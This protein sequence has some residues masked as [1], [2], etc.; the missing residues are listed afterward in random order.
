MVD[1]ATYHIPDPL[2]LCVALLGL[3]YLL[4]SQ[5]PILPHAVAAVFSYGLLWAVAA[6]FQRY[7]GY[8][9]LGLGDAKLL[10]A[11]AFWV[12][13]L[14]LAPVLLLASVS[15]IAAVL[16]LRLIAKRHLEQPLAF[17]PFLAFAIFV[18]WL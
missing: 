13:P 3:V 2:N 1:F 8:A 10:A 11:G 7:R 15:G 12:G 17:G 16:A 18:I 14:G 5:A 9:G 4:H 6:L